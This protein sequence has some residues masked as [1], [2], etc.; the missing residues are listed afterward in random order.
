MM[1]QIFSKKKKKEIFDRVDCEQMV[2]EWNI[3]PG[4]NTL[5]LSEEVISLQYRLGETPENFTGII[6]CRWFNIS[7]G[8]RDYEQECRA[9]ARLVSLEDVEKDNGHSLVLVLRKKWYSVK[10]YSPQ[11]VWDNIAEKMLVEFAESGCPIFRAT[12]PLSRGQLKCKGYEKL[13]IYYA[14]DLETIETIFRVLVSANQLSLCGAVAEICEECEPCNMRKVRPVV[15]GHSSSSF[16]LNA[17]KTEIPLDCD[18][19]AYQFFAIAT[20]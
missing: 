19:P 7:F 16:L 18:D 11:G 12:T 15:M 3:L 2:F 8:T 10:E 17:I 4:I 9:N 6:F 13:S 20:T 14:A 5:Q 1:D